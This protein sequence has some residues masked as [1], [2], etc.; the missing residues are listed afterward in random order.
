MKK[1]LV[2]SLALASAMVQADTIKDRIHAIE[3]GMI[4]FQNGRVALMKTSMEGLEVDSLI[5]AEVDDQSNLISFKELSAPRVLTEGLERTFEAVEE[6][7]PFEP[8]VVPNMIAM[9]KIFDS[10]DPYYKR[11]SECTDRAHVWAHDEFKRSGIKSQKIFVFFTASYINSVGL[12]WWFHVAPLYTVNHG[13]QM[14]EMVAD[15]RYTTHPMTIKE[16][17]D[18][19][20]FT[21]RPCKLTTKF[22]EYDVNPQTENCYLMYGTMHDKLPGDLSNQE[23]GQFKTSTSESEINFSRRLAFEL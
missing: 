15:F 16:W 6:V 18:S 20:V 5:S 2:L 3:D 23:R 4:K 17:T 12:K 11:I 22:S 1:L 14:K 7:T 9:Q 19:F 21:K 8:T 10:S 13:G